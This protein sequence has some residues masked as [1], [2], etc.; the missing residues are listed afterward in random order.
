[1][2]Y[3]PAVTRGHG[4][5]FFRR[6]VQL[7]H[8]DSSAR[9]HGV[10]HHLRTRLLVGSLV[11]FPLVVTIF[12]GRFIFNLLDRWFRPI[13]NHYLGFPVPGA[14][15]ILFLLGLYLLGV[16]ATNVFGSRILHLL[17]RGL[18]RLPVL[19][20]IYQGARQIT[21]AIQLRGTTRFQR[22]VLVPYP[23]AGLRAIAFVTQESVRLGT[24][25]TDE[26]VLVFVPTTPN[27]T[28]GF[29]VVVPRRDVTP[30]DLSV[31]DGVRMVISGGLLL[32][33]GLERLQPGET[34]QLETER[35]GEEPRP[36]SS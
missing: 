1:M 27:P 3:D 19:G 11:A 20:P 33:D 10:G 25:G 31:E 14:G 28:S 15:L 4:D 5:P 26:S 13:S 7:G 17:E 23:S 29:L 18:Q 16:L 32:P 12:F 9:G 24:Y 34:P 2:R 30:L 21:A 22:V 36:A 6:M 35:A 8:R